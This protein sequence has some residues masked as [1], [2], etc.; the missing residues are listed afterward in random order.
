MIAAVLGSGAWGTTF[1]QVLADAGCTV[2]L[3]GRNQDVALQITT[4]HV[5][6]RYLPGIE[7][8]E[9]VT[10]TTDVAAALDGVDLV[11]VAIPS[12]SARATLVGTE[13]V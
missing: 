3:W 12:Q 2:R 7:L 10:A 1:A 9:S 11:V 4:E 5:N 13:R 6:G 8:P